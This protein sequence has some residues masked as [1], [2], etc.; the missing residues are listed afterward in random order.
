M[1]YYP[2]I[3]SPFKRTDAKSKTVNLEVFIDETTK[4]L[5]EIG[6]YA[7]EKIDG[8]NLNVIY[9]GNEIS[10]KGHT[11]KTVWN[12][13]VL[14]WLENTFINNN[15]FIQMCEQKFGE[16]SVCFHGELIGPK[17][18]SN[19]YKLENYKFICFDISE[20]KEGVRVWYSRAAL[21]SICTDLYMDFSP[22]LYFFP[23]S[24]KNFWTT[25][26]SKHH[27]GINIIRA[28][29]IKYWAE[30]LQKEPI[31]SYINP[32]KEIEGFVIRPTVELKNN[33]GDRI[34][35][36][37]KVQDILGRSPNNQLAD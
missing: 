21:E 13:D 26:L 16:K 23:E 9:D 6:F 37:V 8:C 30:I 11:D 22:M 29:S 15:A 19:L 14:I 31:R 4:L 12:N 5:S 32:R 27:A 18:Q 20:V 2:K 25:V 7:T 34:I 17:I 1:H 35:Y 33:T 3:S 28:E 36:K 24:K 10:V